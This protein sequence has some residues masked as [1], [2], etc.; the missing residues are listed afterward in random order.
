[1]KSVYQHEKK[2]LFLSTAR[3]SRI[4]VQPLS[5][6]YETLSFA[7]QTLSIIYQILS[8]TYRRPV[9]PLSAGIAGL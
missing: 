3:T 4:F 6:T 2:Y 8:F 5:I 7:Y 9:Y 1:M